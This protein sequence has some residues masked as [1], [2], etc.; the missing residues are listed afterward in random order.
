MIIS[1]IYNIYNITISLKKSYII[2][3]E[4]EEEKIR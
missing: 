3:E 2:E 4:E 1:Y